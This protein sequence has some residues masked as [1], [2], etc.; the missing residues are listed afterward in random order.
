MLLDLSSAFD[1]LV[2][3]IIS[4]SLNEIGRS[5]HGKIQSWFIYF[6]SSR[7]SSVKIKSSLSHH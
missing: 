7:T 5:I 1:T 4:I 2:H 6:V 3:N